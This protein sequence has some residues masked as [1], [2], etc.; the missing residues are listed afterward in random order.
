MDIRLDCNA[1]KTANSMTATQVAKF[2][3]VVRTIGVCLTDTFDSGH[4]VRAVYIHIYRYG[5][6]ERHVKREY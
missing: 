2:S 4:S 5:E 6:L 1:C 3:G